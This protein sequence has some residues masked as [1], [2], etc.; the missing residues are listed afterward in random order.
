MYNTGGLPYSYWIQTFDDMGIID[1]MNI[2]CRRMKLPQT[3]NMYANELC[4][5]T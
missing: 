1:M 4:E 3:I 2:C 5:F